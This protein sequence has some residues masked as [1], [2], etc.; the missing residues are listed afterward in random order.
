[1]KFSNSRKLALV[2]GIVLLTALL[3]IGWWIGTNDPED[4]S[5]VPIVAS[6]LTSS[7]NDD[8][9]TAAAAAEETQTWNLEE[10]APLFTPE[11]VILNVECRMRT[12]RGDAKDVAVLTFF[13][14]NGTEFTVLGDSG[15]LARGRTDFRGHKTRIGQ[16]ADGSVVFGLGD[17]RLNSGVFRE[18][19]TDEPVKIYHNDLVIYE[20]SKA[21]NFGVAD[22]GTSF[23][24]HEPAPGGA[25]RLVVRDLDR[26]TQV[27]YD[28]GTRLSPVNDYFSVIP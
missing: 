12:G 23:F 20:T 11:R 1:M 8:P 15:A 28:L 18:A 5:D 10:E 7:S 4:L 19:D 16:R 24:A 6:T 3:G 22:D 25:S 9:S 13:D 14:E 27:E 21:W 26:D 2:G 17:L